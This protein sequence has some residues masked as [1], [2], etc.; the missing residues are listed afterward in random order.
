MQTLHWDPACC[1]D[2]YGRDTAA[3]GC[4]WSA[5]QDIVATRLGGGGIGTPATGVYVG[6][7]RLAEIPATLSADN[8]TV[9][10]FAA[11]GVGQVQ[12]SVGELQ[13]RHLRV[14][15]LSPQ[16][17]SAAVTGGFFMLAQQNVQLTVVS[18]RGGAVIQP[19]RNL[20]P[21]PQTGEFTWRGAV[22]ASAGTPHRPVYVFE[23]T[24]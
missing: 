9:L 22:P 17:V 4:Q 1:H 18:D 5:C 21:G 11:N 19:S 14:S 12:L 3:Q 7:S 23:K 6:S 15:F 24:A 8:T 13:H 16:A 20:W 2:G 10:V